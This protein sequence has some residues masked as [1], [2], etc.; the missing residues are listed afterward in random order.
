[1]HERII[2]IFAVSIKKKYLHLFEFEADLVVLL[3]T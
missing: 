2:N 1:M 3:V